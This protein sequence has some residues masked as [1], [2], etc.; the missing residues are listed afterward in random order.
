ML[1]KRFLHIQVFFFSIVLN[2]AIISLNCF[3]SDSA[4]VYCDIWGVPHIYAD[5]EE[6]VHSDLGIARQP[7][8]FQHPGLNQHFF[9]KKN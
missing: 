2:T 8:F 1:M 6:N 3:D 5:S 9:K 7:D 4:T